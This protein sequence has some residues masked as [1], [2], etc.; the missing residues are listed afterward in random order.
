[1]PVGFSI[2]VKWLRNYLGNTVNTLLN[3]RTISKGCA[4]A[5][6]KTKRYR[7]INARWVELSKLGRNKERNGKDLHLILLE[8]N[9][10]EA[11]DSNS[12]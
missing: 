5:T 12:P 1:M 3:K 10:T 6:N 4:K 9:I 2:N 8:Y 11:Q 7:W